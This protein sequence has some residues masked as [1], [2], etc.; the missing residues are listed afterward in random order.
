[1]HTDWSPNSIGNSVL[2]LASSFFPDSNKVGFE[3]SPQFEWRAVVDGVNELRRGVYFH[4]KSTSTSASRHWNVVTIS[5]LEESIIVVE[6]I[7]ESQRHS[8]C[9]NARQCRK[10]LFV[11]RLAGC[12]KR[13]IASF[14]LMCWRQR[15]YR[16]LWVL[17]S[18]YFVSNGTCKCALLH[19]HKLPYQHYTHIICPIVNINDLHIKFGFNQI[20]YI[21]SL[22]HRLRCLP[23][24]MQ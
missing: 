23:V 16:K 10:N 14:Y 17:E 19:Q 20:M 18:L 12:L 24:M 15:T 7:V 3:F 4:K 9:R 6:T 21:R 2:L 11:C 1:M 13:K 22:S 5:P 8:S